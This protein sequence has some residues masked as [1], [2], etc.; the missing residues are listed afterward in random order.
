MFINQIERVM[1]FKLTI[2]RLSKLA[3]MK[4]EYNIKTVVNKTNEC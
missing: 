1:K 3:N 2:N 4:N